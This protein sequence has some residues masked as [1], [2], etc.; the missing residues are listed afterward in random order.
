MLHACVIWVVTITVKLI[1]YLSVPGE[2]KKTATEHAAYDLKNRNGSVIL[3][4]GSRNIDR[5]NMF[6]LVIKLMWLSDDR[7]ILFQ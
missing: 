6:Y 3:N 4:P 5:N 2:W 1:G 7:Y